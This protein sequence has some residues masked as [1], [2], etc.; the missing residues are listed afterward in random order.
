[1]LQCITAMRP[2]HALLLFAAILGCDREGED[3]RRSDG[4]VFSSSGGEVLLSDG[5]R[6]EFGITSDKYKRWDRAQE[7]IPHDVAERFGTLLRPRSPT[8]RSIESAIGYLQRQPAARSAIERAGM[9]VREFVLM[10]VALE[11]EMQLAESRGEPAEQLPIMPLD[12]TPL[13]IPSPYPPQ[14]PPPYPGYAYP[15]GYP[16]VDTLYRPQPVLPP[17]I[18]PTPVAPRADTTRVDTLFARP[19]PRDSVRSRRDTIFLP[20]RRDTVRDTVKTPPPD[21]MESR[22]PGSASDTSSP[23][24]AGPDTTDAA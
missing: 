18:V 4:S 13:P 24:T 12:T 23:P 22:R 11:Q 14:Y 21:T 6:L 8:E 3:L 5:G 20:P 1:M 2:A 7:G 15:P 19:A 16:P 9:T 10:T 17:P